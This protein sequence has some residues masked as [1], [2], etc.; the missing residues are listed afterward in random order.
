VVE[1]VAIGG[2]KGVHSIGEGRESGCKGE[3]EHRHEGDDG[4]E[5][6]ERGGQVDVGVQR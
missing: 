2:Q 4:G 5:E 1:I 3:I 6:M